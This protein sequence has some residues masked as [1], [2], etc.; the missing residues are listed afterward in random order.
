MS[1]SITACGL[2]CAALIRATTALR[3]MSNRL[4]DLGIA[5]FAAAGWCLTA[6]DRCAAFADRLTPQ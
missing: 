2:K 6:G 1:Q 5:I 4:R 3:W